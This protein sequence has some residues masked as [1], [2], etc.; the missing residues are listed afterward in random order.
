MDGI[1]LSLRI[2][3]QS[4]EVKINNKIG[5]GRLDLLYPYDRDYIWTLSGGKRVSG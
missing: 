3:R 5:S 2:N 1:N 4:N